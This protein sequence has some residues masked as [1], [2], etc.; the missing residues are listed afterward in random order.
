MALARETVLL[1]KRAYLLYLSDPF[2]RSMSSLG[3]E[4]SAGISIS[5]D[6][7]ADAHFPFLVREG[8]TA[9]NSWPSLL[10]A[11]RLTQ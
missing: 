9:G 1:V 5:C 4:L 11:A 3:D 10:R 2:E 6:P 8:G 7:L